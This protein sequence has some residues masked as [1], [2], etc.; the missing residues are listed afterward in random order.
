MTHDEIFNRVFADLTARYP[1]LN[2]IE[3]ELKAAFISLCE[4]FA[5]SGTL[6]LC[7]NGGSAA[8]AE[9]IIGE[10]M[11]PYKMDRPVDEGFR[12]KLSLLYPDEAEHFC[13]NLK[14]ALPC[15]ALGAQTGFNSAYINDHAPD[16]LY[17]QLVYGLGKPGDVLFGITTSGSSKNVVNALKVAHAMGMN[18]VMLTSEK[19][20]TAPGG[21]VAIRVPGTEC[22][23]V[24][25]LHLP[26]YHA[27]CEMLESYFFTQ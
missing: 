26:V 9:H 8:D 23:P 14:K 19:C 22:C 12:A 16:M 13:R 11:Q 18:T 2:S 21:C 15:F 24:Q 7:G 4:C 20:K 27:L 5:G 25:E 10:L 17:A 1:T 3:N 6:Y